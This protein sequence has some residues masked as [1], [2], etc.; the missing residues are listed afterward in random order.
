MKCNEPAIDPKIL[1]Y[2]TILIICYGRSGSTLLQGILNSIDSVLVKGENNN[3]FYHFYCAYRELLANSKRFNNSASPTHP[4]FGSCW[5]DKD[6]FIHDFRQLAHNLLA[7]NL[8]TESHRFTTLGFK[9]IR[10]PRLE[11]PVPYIEFLLSVFDTPCIIHL[12]RNHYTTALSQSK[13]FKNKKSASIT[14]ILSELERFDNHMKTLSTRPYYFHID[15]EEMVGT[16]RRVLTE[17]FFFLGADYNKSTI[18]G[19]MS[20]PH[21]Y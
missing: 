14:D 2:K 3:V 15:Y 5:F 6:K 12:T 10:Y 9:E 11:N 21:S 1:N 20:I 18:D 7:S 4:W 8:T 13:K 17:L 16:D 19:I